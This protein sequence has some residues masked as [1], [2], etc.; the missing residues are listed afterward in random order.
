VPSHIVTTWE[1][2]AGGKTRRTVR[3][4][5]ASGLLILINGREV[6]PWAD[7]LSF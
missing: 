7:D 2:P 1:I 5:A 6:Q 3:G 4:F